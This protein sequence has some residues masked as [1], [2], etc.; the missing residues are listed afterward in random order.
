MLCTFRWLAS[1]RNGGTSYVRDFVEFGPVT[2]RTVAGIGVLVCKLT[3][4]VL[5]GL[6]KTLRVRT[7]K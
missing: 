6:A 1:L 2:V 7:T 4:S 5:P 3:N